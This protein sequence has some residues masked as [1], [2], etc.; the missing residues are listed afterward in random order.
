MAWMETPEPIC[1]AEVPL[2]PPVPALE[3]RRVWLN[4][5]ARS[6]RPPLKAVVLTFATLLPMTS[7]RTWKFCRPL[8]AEVRDRSMCF[9]DG[10]V[11]SRRGDAD[12]LRQVVLFPVDHEFW[13]PFLHLHGGD[14]A[15]DSGL[16]F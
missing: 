15:S 9:G 12:Q 4:E 7:M 13:R 3:L 1:I 14:L 10:L 11:K 6:T 16:R 8:M 5:S 2:L